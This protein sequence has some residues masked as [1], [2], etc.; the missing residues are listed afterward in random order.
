[1]ASRSDYQR[2]STSSSMDAGRNTSSS[3]GPSTSP[4][5]AATRNNSR[6]G[7]VPPA[8]FV[9]IA[10]E[11]GLILPMSD[12]ILREA[13]RQAASWQMPLYVSVN[14]SPVQFQHGDLPGLVHSVLLETGLPAHRLQL[15]IY[16]FN[17]RA[18]RHAERAG[19]TREGIRRKAY[20]RNEQWVDGVLFGLVAEDLEAQPE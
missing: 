15:E 14:L 6:C 3:A 5:R 9:P 18:I 17:E 12:W 20:W 19:F 10:E 4:N 1:M 7:Y 2:E 13:C 8:T 16:A 11:S